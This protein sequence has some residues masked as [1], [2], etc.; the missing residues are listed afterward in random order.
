[1][2]G[3]RSQ[4]AMDIIKALRE[5]HAEKKRLDSVIASLEA[6]LVAA[7]KQGAARKKP[8]TPW[9][10]KHERGRA[11]GSLQTNDTVLGSPPGS[12]PRAQR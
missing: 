6:R 5:L 3:P 4:S 9:Q 7:R 2:E 12:T 8:R 10:K 1:M 11:S